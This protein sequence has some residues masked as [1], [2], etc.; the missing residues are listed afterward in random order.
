MTRSLISPPAPSLSGDFGGLAN[1]E[2][3]LR[4]LIATLKTGIHFVRSVLE[5][6]PA[7]RKLLTSG[8]SSVDVVREAIVLL[9]M[10]RQVIW[11]AFYI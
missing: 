9:A 8:N 10:C 3:T 5:S 6:L 11:L 1:D 2:T 4:T 7:V